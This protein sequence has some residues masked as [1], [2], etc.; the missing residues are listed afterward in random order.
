M[1]LMITQSGGAGPAT[2]TSREIAE[3]TGKEHKN[4]CRD[5]RNM[6]EELGKDRLSFERTYKDACGRDQQEYVLDRELTLTLVS[7]Y[8]IPLRHRVV[9]KLSE[10]ENQAK[11]SHV[12]IPQNLAEALRLA[13]DL[14]EQKQLAEQ[15]AE[16]AERTKAEIGTRREATAM[17]TASAATKRANQLQV[18]LDR[19]MQYATVK[20]MEAAFR[21]R[22]FNWRVLKA[23]SNELGIPTIDVPDQN[24]TTV[25]AY[26]ADAWR[27]AYSVDVPRI[28]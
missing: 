21:G 9:T 22:R 8:D 15:R 7:G 20:R 1:T 18:E 6:L 11:G 19:A 16:I 25:K 4:V 14:A 10:L 2:M 12:A 5:I 3:L 17:Q 23:M 26:H 28:A 27:K 13:A 24:Y